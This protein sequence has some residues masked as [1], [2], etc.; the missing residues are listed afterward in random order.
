M[1][2]GQGQDPTQRLHFPLLSQRLLSGSAPVSGP[3]GWP[4]GKSS[5]LS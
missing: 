4:L 5:P 3:W 1:G 2:A